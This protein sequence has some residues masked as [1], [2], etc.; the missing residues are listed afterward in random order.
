MTTPDV[1]HD[2]EGPAALDRLRR[3]GGDDLVRELAVIFYETSH[4]RLADVRAG[5]AANDRRAVAR[6][7]HSL[8]G[9]CGQIGAVTA[10]QLARELERDAG[11]ADASALLALAERVDRAC[12]DYRAALA[13]ELRAREMTS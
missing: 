4:Q 8:R 10:A 2:A 5:V 13:R 6:A 11:T 3:F 9:S 12:A 7:A 1:V